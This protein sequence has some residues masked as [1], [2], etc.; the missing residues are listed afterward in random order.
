M[1]KTSK[2][3]EDNVVLCKA[4]ICLSGNLMGG[5]ETKKLE[6]ILKKIILSGAQELIIEMN[7]VSWINT[8]GLNTLIRCQKLLKQA[9][10][11]LILATPSAK[12]KKLL[13]ITGHQKSFRII[14]SWWRHYKFKTP[15][16]NLQK[17]KGN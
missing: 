16:K 4:T 9:H 8:A 12:V 3:H 13:K 17:N 7:Q 11:Q 15:D 1:S 14:E 10:G 2:T 6:R 5:P